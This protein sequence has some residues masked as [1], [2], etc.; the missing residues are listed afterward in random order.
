[1]NWQIYQPEA[2]QEPFDCYHAIGY[3]TYEEGCL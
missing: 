3:S 2:D 1:M